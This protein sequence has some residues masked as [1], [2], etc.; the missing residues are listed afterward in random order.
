VHGSPREVSALTGGACGPGS[1]GVKAGPARTPVMADVA[2]LAGVSHQT[3]SRVLNGGPNV[4]PATRMRVA[5]AI[6]ELEYQPNAAARALATRRSRA[7]GVIGAS[8]GQHGPAV[9]LSGIEAAARAAGYSVIL[10]APSPGGRAGLAGCVQR[11]AASV[12][13]IIVVATDADLTEA[14]D[15]IVPVVT[16][17]SPA[18]GAAASVSA[19][20]FDGAYRATAY[21]LDLGH[22]TVHFLTGPPV[23]RAA[24]DRE[25]GWRRALDEQGAAAPE[26]LVAVDSNARSGYWAGRRLASARLDGEEPTAVLCAADPLAL[27]LM[28]AV[29]QAG[30]RTPEDLSVI[31]FDDIP[32]AEFFGPALTTVRQ[33]FEGLGRQAFDALLVHIS[34]PRA[35][36]SSVSSANTA[37]SVLMD[38][39]IRNSCA[40]RPGPPPGGSVGAR[41]ADAERERTSRPGRR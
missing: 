10:T 17:G 18:P 16:V 32:G 40:R 7:L 20:N 13:G 19:G 41:P 8:H 34:A 36:G 14:P 27:G 37:A 6:R 39:V 4:R 3:V 29:Q 5:A 9:I 38:L 26:P 28:R 35:P 24:R 12:D 25:A 33:N 30:M 23:S 2:R 11:L 21:L 22:R 31:G 1:D 15:W